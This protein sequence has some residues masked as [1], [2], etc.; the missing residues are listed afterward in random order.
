MLYHRRRDFDWLGIRT[1]VSFCFEPEHHD[2]RVYSRDWLLTLQ[3][4]H[5]QEPHGLVGSGLLMREGGGGGPPSSRSGPTGGFEMRGGPRG[6]P[7]MGGP[8]GGPPG[9]AAGG[10]PA[11]DNSRW[12]RGSMMPPPSGPPGECSLLPAVPA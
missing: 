9:V 4:G 3:D 2:C 8:H 5:R 12:D 1:T 11:T 10:L 7:H 6:A